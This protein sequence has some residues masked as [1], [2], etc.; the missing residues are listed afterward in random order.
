MD[1]PKQM[2]D[3]LAQFEQLRGQVQMLTNQKAHME[4]Q[5]KEVEH[6]IDELE[7]VDKKAPIY[8]SIGSVLVK[9]KDVKTVKKELT[10]QKDTLDIRIKAI[11]K[12]EESVKEKYL[13]LQQ[14]INQ[15]FDKMSG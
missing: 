10:E 14:K 8:K 11:S 15:A 5:A 6:A 9:A 13:E 2:Q 1:I 7:K 12:Q 3:Q 4:A